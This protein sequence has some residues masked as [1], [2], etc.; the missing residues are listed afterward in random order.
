VIGTVAVLAI[1]G[2]AAAFFVLRGSGEQLLRRI[3]EGT[4]VVVTAYLDPSASQK[5]N[6]LRMVDD[7]PALGTREDLTDRIDGL[8]DGA[9]SGSG[10]D[11]RDLGW[12]GSQVAIVV[13]V[14]A[15]GSGATS[16]GLLIVTDD[17]A[18]ATSSL[19]HLRAE[20][21]TG[22]W[23]SQEFEGTDVWSHAGA[24]GVDD[25]YALVDGVVVVG[26]TSDLV[27][28]V[29]A[30]T[31]SERTPIEESA[32]FQAATQGLPEG[33]L[34]LAYVDPADL[35][36]TIE[37]L[38]G[39]D[40][41]SIGTGIADLDVYRGFAVSVSA[42]ADGLAVDA[43]VAY[44]PS[45]MTDEMRASLSA[46]AA[47]NALLADVPQDALVVLEQVGLDAGLRDAVEEMRTTD[48]QLARMLDR[49][50]LTSSGVVESLTGDVAVTG[51]PADDVGATGAL[52]IG[53]GDEQAMTRALERLGHRVP[54]L[55]G[56]FDP[57]ESESLDGVSLSLVPPARWATETYAGIEVHTLAGPTTLDPFRLSY[58]VVEGAGVI[59]LTPEAVHGV[60]DTQQGAPSIRDAPAYTDALA[61]VPSGR[62]SLYVDIDGIG[63]AVRG[64][65]PPDALESYDRDVGP[66]LEHLDA[67]VVGAESSVDRTRVRMFLRVA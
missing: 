50:G 55:L 10:L 12:V 5:V 67:F 26:T 11:H 54:E 61:T 16:V 53:T 48:P 22:S 4:D 19:E 25:A 65:L 17:E 35:I 39:F 34:G 27:E 45:K 46:P 64:S 29:I 37:Q 18:A 31:N 36:T 20:T 30:T 42:E 47:E 15:E 44:D 9:L 60:I 28:G 13:D 6:L 8:I 49:F 24:T 32:D 33:K 51:S 7:V 23:S 2:G 66:S 63:D 38:P 57:A 14:P 52:L 1:A 21:P 41:A 40:A 56:P 3:P 62:G 58:A 59:G 43:Q